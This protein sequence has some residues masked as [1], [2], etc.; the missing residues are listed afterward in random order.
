MPIDPLIKATS[1]PESPHGDE[2]QIPLMRNPYQ[3]DPQNQAE[4]E[5]GYEFAQ[6]MGHTQLS[7]VGQE[8]I[9]RWKN[10][11]L[12]W[13]AG[14]ST[15]TSRFG[16]ESIAKMVMGE[17][18]EKQAKARITQ[19]IG[20]RVGRAIRRTL[21]PAKTDKEHLDEA[22]RTVAE[23]YYMDPDQFKEPKSEKKAMLWA[24]EYFTKTAMIVGGNTGSG[25]SA[26]SGTPGQA[27]TPMSPTKRTGI[28]GSP[29][30]DGGAPIGRDKMCSLMLPGTEKI[31]GPWPAAI[32]HGLT[33]ALAGGPVGPL[34]GV[35]LS[36]AY[37]MGNKDMA[38]HMGASP[39]ET[40]AAPGGF[41]GGAGRGLITALGTGVG[42]IGGAMIAPHVGMDP[43]A[44]AVLGGAATGL[45]TSYMLG[46]GAALSNIREMRG[47][48]A[49]QGI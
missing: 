12:A 23:D 1:G 25:G 26:G 28:L 18:A 14:F 45:P 16:L 2:V 6:S 13:R 49:T 4:F 44:G 43:T 32:G 37:N 7:Q 27:M 41:L 29:V 20:L 31:A 38:Q 39:E 10:Q 8:D 5:N 15:A 35:P 33:S 30:P 3:G 17:D 19:R 22:A 24:T 36:Y 34:A 47:A 48:Q 11:S 40:E 9:D 46:R 42:S 21:H